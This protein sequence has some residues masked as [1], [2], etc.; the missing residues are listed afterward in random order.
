MNEFRSLEP[1]KLS[2][3]AVLCDIGDGL[4]KSAGSSVVWINRKASQAAD[5]LAKLALKGEVPRDWVCCPPPLL[6][7][8]L[9]MDFMGFGC[10]EV[11]RDAL[12]HENMYIIQH[13]VPR[14]G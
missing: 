13:T 12:Q 6:A 2:S 5:W 14:Y 9:M 7:S 1:L 3:N 8:F 4:G 10:M 11:D